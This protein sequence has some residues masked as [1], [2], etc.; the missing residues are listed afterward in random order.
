ML[1]KKINLPSDA[2]LPVLRHPPLP[3]ALREERIEDLTQYTVLVVTNS[4]MSYTACRG[5]KLL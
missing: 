2:G 4:R 1:V 3:A 5:A